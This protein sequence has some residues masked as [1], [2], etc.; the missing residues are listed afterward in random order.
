MQVA[1]TKLRKPLCL[2]LVEER[3][4]DI[5]AVQLLQP[6]LLLFL[7]FDYLHLCVITTP[8][9]HRGTSPP[10]HELLL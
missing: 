8:M 2:I 5:C 10:V 3:V 4:V 6:L 7:R 1:I 9:S